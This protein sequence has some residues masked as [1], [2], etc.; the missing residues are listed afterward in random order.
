MKKIHYILISILLVIL[1]AISIIF[2]LSSKPEE[3]VSTP[4]STNVVRILIDPGH[5]AR[6]PGGSG[7]IGAEHIYSYRVSEY[8]AKILDKDNRFRYEL[9]RY[10]ADSED[11]NDNIIEYAAYNKNKLMGMIKTKVLREKRG[12][13]T[14]DQYV[15]MYAIR[16]YAIENNFDCLVSIHFDVA[17]KRYYNQVH[18]F[19]VLV[20]PYNRTF[21]KS[22]DLARA[23]SS[24]FMKEYGVARGVRHDSSFNN[25]H[26][27]WKE[28]DRLGLLANGV[29]FR[30]LV[31]IG[32]V[33]ESGYYMN[34]YNND[35]EFV[36]NIIDIP[37]V[38][39]EVGYLH[40][41]K[42][43]NEH[44]LQDVAQRIYTA[45]KDTFPEWTVQ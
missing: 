13:L 12:Y 7:P 39:I 44:V 35:I 27:I 10:H 15:D 45:I 6:V 26:V 17:D 38:L 8:L 4:P 34:R 11:Y 36:A 20:S 21:E 37:S 43:T 31:V 3:L 33:F 29:G 42:F 22:Y 24:N 5:T 32:D 9:S 28:Y 2:V 41:E 23:V 19:H 30:S 14:D 18:G 40:E 1:I 16:H 25:S